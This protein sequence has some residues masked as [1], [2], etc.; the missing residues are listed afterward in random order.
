[1]RFFVIKNHDIG[2]LAAIVVKNDSD[3]KIYFSAYNKTY[4]EVLRSI[5]SQKK[6]LVESRE[7]GRTIVRKEVRKGDPSYFD[8]LKDRIDSPY[9]VHVGGTVQEVRPEDALRKLWAMFSPKE[10]REI[11]SV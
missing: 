1:M 7:D 10:V 3:E 2:I 5:F 8:V 11:V 6:F 9:A 4:E